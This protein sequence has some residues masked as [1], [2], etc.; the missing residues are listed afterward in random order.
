LG[1]IA[2]RT[3]SQMSYSNVESIGKRRVILKGKSLKKIKE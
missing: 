1:D 2:D 3:S